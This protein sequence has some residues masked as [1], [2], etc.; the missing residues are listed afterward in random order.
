[1]RRPIVGFARDE[2]GDWTA[3]LSCGHAQHVRHQPPFVNRAWVLSEEGRAGRL[4]EVLDCVRCDRRELPEAFAPYRRT[5]VFAEDTVP[6]GLKSSHTT[7]PG[8]WARIVVV[9]GELRYRVETLG[10]DA[11]L[12]PGHDGIVVPEAPHEV[13][14][15]G[16]VRFYV[17]FYRALPGA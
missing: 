15:V 13:E 17:E 12:S 10:I 14:P 16:A 3:Q 7:A 1:M 8:I 11:V 2:H 6:A 4:G 5:P 9:S